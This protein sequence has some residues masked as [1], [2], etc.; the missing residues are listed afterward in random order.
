MQE[1]TWQRNGF[2]AVALLMIGMMLSLTIVPA[3]P[4][5]AQDEEPTPTPRDP[6]WLGFS[7]AREAIQEE[8]GVDLS[9]V[10]SWEFWQDDWSVAEGAHPQNATG[11]DSCDTE[12]LIQ[13]ARPVYFGWTYVI[14]ALN[15][16][17]Y[18][19]RVSF[20]LQD[21]VLCDIMTEMSTPAVA[22]DDGGETANTE[23][24]VV[25]AGASGEFELGGHATGFFPDAVQ[26]MQRSNMTWVKIQVPMYAGVQYGYDRI[27]EAKANGFKI[28]I[29]LVGNEDELGADFEGYVDGLA[30]YAGAMAEAGADAIEV[31]NEPNL[32]REWPEDQINGAR[33]TE[34]LS[35]V[36]NRIKERNPN[37]MVISAAMAPTGAFGEAGCGNL[38]FESGCNDD[39]FMQQMAQAGA[40]NYADCI[41]V[42][43]NEG[44]VSPGTFSGDPR[45]EFPTYYFGS[46][47]NR[48]AQYF[49]NRPI[50]YTELGYLSPEG[51]GAPLPGNFAWAADTSLAEHA[52]WLGEVVDRAQ[53]R[54]DIR[55]LIVWNVDFDRWD[56]DPMGGY[57]ILRPD[58]SCPA[59]DTLANA[60]RN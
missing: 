13:F 14:T 19:A 57:A 15:G 4:V 46:M 12:T 31:W 45:G 25:Q 56:S 49:P 29:G 3:T 22:T 43:Y 33:Y 34:M 18:E 28:L 52:A 1:K 5:A 54:G 10:R 39:V 6:A 40:A 55:M 24:A 47:T 48:V 50:C 2:I 59:C 11:I 26:A 21:V 17:V 53:Q 23:D 37:T 20:D 7:T 58:G 51:M 44:I 35:V 42:H 9:V 38:G 36:Y 30:T 32:G 16:N 27:N 8:E 41:G 60:V